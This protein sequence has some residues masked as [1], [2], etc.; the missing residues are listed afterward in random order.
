MPCFLCGEER[1]MMYACGQCGNNI[2]YICNEVNLDKDRCCICN[3]DEY[4]KTRQL[5]TRITLGNIFCET[6]RITM[7]QSNIF[8]I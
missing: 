7:I 2:C 6:N 4:P 3:P 8:K 5:A 1:N